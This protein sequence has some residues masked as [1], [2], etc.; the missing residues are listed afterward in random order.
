MANTITN[1]PSNVAQLLGNTDG[2]KNAKEQNILSPA[3]QSAHQKAQDLLA[4]QPRDEF[5][6]S[7]KGLQAAA[8]IEKYQNTYAYSQTMS[9]SLT[10]QEGDTVKVDFRQLYA[11]YQEYKHQQSAEV[12]PKG[13]RMFESKE[14]L[15]ATAFEEQFGFSVEGNLNENELK[16]VFD[17]FEQVDSLANEFYG[18]NIEAALQKAQDLNVDFGQIKNMSL[19]LQ[20]S[21]A[22]STSYQQAAAYKG[23][24]Q[25]P[26]DA[27]QKPTYDEQAAGNIA[28]LPPYLQKWQD[29]INRLN[30]Q[31]A[32]AR[33]A[34]DELMSGVTAQ[35]FPEQDTQPG[36]YER[37]KGFHDRL[38]EAAK[39]D[40]IT[41][42]PSGVEIPTGPLVSDAESATENMTEQ[43]EENSSETPKETA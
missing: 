26:A 12:G 32:N 42:A 4:K 25:T 35:R 29:A 40:K 7:A 37:I 21:E 39:L 28:D 36:W 11:Q 5:S 1:M 22:R 2:S 10:T 30:E 6:P 18:G 15:E 20:K 3:Q 24:A 34:F 27:Q 13:A 38:A 31:F 33:S 17:V 14:A 23:V 9:M 19:D 8:S 16:A 41:L 43:G